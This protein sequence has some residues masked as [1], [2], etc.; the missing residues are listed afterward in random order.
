M[1][2]LL[3]PRRL[4]KSVNDEKINMQE[5]FKVFSFVSVIFE[6]VLVMPSESE[7]YLYSLDNLFLFEY[8]VFCHYTDEII[9]FSDDI[10]NNLRVSVNL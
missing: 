7:G 2:C 5:E 3:W 10:F 9:H 8:N 4:L 6:N 1:L